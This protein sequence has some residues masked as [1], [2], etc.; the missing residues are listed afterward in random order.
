[1]LWIFYQFGVA[2]Y[3]IVPQ[4]ISAQIT[5][6]GVMVDSQITVNDVTNYSIL[7]IMASPTAAPIDVTALP[8]LPVL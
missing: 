4:V 8:V 7:P 6:S 1:M 5:L 3:D 2:Y